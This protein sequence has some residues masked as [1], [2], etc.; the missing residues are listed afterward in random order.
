MVEL[1]QARA[2]GR[3]VS[4]DFAS[5]PIT[6]TTTNGMMGGI[7]S[8]KGDGRRPELAHQQ[9]LFGKD[10]P[11]VPVWDMDVVGEEGMPSPFLK[12]DGGRLVRGLR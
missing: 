5:A 3:P 8:G 7:G 12:R 2:G 6:A 10:L 11:P 4:V 1:A 9:L